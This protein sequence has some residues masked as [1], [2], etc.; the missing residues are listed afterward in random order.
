MKPP[1]S[2]PKRPSK[3]DTEPPEVEL[4]LEWVHGY[5]GYDSRNNMQVMANGSL[6][7]YVAGV[8]CSYDPVNHA[9]KHFIKHSDDVTSIAFSPDKKYICTGELGKKPVAYVTDF[10]TMTQVAELKGNGIKESI[11]AVTYSGSG[12]LL[13]VVA[14]DQD[15]NI[16][17]YNTGD[18]SLLA[19]GKGDRMHVR[20]IEFNPSDDNEFVIVGTKLFKKFTISGAKFRGKLGQ[21]GTSI[22]PKLTCGIY[23]GQAVLTG[24]TDGD[25]LSWSGLQPKNIKPKLHSKRL[26]AILVTQDYVLTGGKD[27]Q[28]F[29]LNKS[30]ETLTSINLESLYQNGSSVSPQVRALS[31]NEAEDALYVGTFGSEFIEIKLSLAGKTNEEPR[32]F[33]HGHYAPGEPTNEVWGLCTYGE[34]DN[35]KFATVSDDATV[36]IWNAK[37]H[38]QIAY[39]PLD[40]DAEAYP[41]ETQGKNTKLKNAVNRLAKGRSIDI[42]FN[43]HWMAVGTFGG[44]LRVFEE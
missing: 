11:S 1:Q 43:N 35:E 25:L 36:R 15:H 34:G 44:L 41:Y 28:I 16:A 9:Q 30:Y 4:E 6:A 17:I 2:A 24:N 26:D 23:N 19:S 37:T 18:W 27:M 20:D 8:V 29:V 13:A 7:Y 38:K 14:G 5:R 33:T 31:L 42:S 10:A 3:R 21:F 39:L 22:N 40:K 12:K 32:V